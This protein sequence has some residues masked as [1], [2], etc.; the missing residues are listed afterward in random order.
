MTLD[1][2]RHHPCRGFA[3]LLTAVYATRIFL[4]HMLEITAPGNGG[5]IGLYGSRP[6]WH[7]KGGYP[8]IRVPF[9]LPPACLER[10]SLIRIEFLIETQRTMR[11]HAWSLVNQ[12]NACAVHASDDHDS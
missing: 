2:N 11:I 10:G 6:R 1:C 12:N 4:N 7:P 3:D 8:I 9:R 5:Y